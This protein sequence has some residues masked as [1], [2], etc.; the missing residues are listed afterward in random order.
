MPLN[1]ESVADESTRLDSALRVISPA[2]AC[3]HLPEVTYARRLAGADT[4]AKLTKKR[5][6]N[7]GHQ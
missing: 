3:L 7:H 5:K 2:S 6:G 4:C 1:A